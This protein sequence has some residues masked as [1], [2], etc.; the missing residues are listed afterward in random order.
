M[1]T[2]EIIGKTFGEL[3]DVEYEDRKESRMIPVTLIKLRYV[4]VYMYLSHMWSEH[5]CTH[6]YKAMM[7]RPQNIH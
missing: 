4:S 7:M 3:S 1:V 2:W 6:I 5:M